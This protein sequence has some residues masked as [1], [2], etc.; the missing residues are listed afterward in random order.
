M[1]DKSE[2]CF[3]QSGTLTLKVH[4]TTELLDNEEGY[5]TIIA[6]EMKDQLVAL[7]GYEPKWLYEI[8]QEY[9]IV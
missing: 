3:T 5:R 4:Y 8:N 7:L 1:F 9:D 2:F 6:S